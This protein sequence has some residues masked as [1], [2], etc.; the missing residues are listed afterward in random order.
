MARRRQSILAAP[1]RRPARTLGADASD[2]Q[3]PPRLPSAA[4]SFLEACAKL[5]GQAAAEG[6][7]MPW[8]TQAAIGPQVSLRR[9]RYPHM[10]GSRWLLEA[11]HG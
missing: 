9:A 4:P 7:L 11:L 3:G 6:D 5:A 1:D 10:G 8:L 2:L